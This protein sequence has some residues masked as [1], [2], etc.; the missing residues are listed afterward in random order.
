MPLPLFKNSL[1]VLLSLVAPAVVSSGITALRYGIASF[2]TILEP[3]ALKPLS[4]ISIVPHN[5]SAERLFAFVVVSL[6]FSN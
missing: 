6:P 3:S 5:F 4:L 2:E 1:T